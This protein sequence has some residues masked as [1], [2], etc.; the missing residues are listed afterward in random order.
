M[1]PIR[2]MYLKYGFNGHLQCKDCREYRVR[3]YERSCDACGLTGWKGGHPACG[4]AG[5]K[6]LAG[7]MNLKDIPGVIPEGGIRE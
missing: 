4:L 2:K 3:K 5:Q 7:Q 1:R 6:S